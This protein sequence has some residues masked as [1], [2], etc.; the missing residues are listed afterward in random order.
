MRNDRRTG[1]SGYRKAQ[2]RPRSENTAP[3]QVPQSLTDLGVPVIAHGVTLGLAGADRPA[4]DRLTRLAELAEVL[5]SPFVSE[6]VA[7]VRASD[8]PDPLHGDV[9][10]ARHLLPPPVLSL[11]ATAVEAYAG[12]PLPG[13]MLERDTDVSP[14]T[15]DPEFTKLTEAVGQAFGRSAPPVTGA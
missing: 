4:T 14:Q 11:L 8:S 7:F 15:V 5:D 9:L 1:V 6:H 2:H 3:A 12:R 13:V 10:E